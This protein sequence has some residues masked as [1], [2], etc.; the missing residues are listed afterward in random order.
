MD[1]DISVP[2]H[3]G[4]V[5]VGQNISEIIIPFR[6]L[7]KGNLNI[8]SISISPLRY[9]TTSLENKHKTF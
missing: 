3:R 1:T 8:V 2:L 6:K 7:H 9:Y 4:S 5:A